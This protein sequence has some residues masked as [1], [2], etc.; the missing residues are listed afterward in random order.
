LVTKTNEVTEVSISEQKL[1]NPTNQIVLREPGVVQAV[2]FQILRPPPSSYQPP[3]FPQRGIPGQQGYAP[4]D[5]GDQR[6]TH[7]I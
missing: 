4:L 7:T 1:E 2:A 3:S 6:I 5:Y